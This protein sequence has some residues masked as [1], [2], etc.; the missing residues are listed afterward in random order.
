MTLTM[1]QAR[2][3]ADMTQQEV[4]DVLGVHVQ[5]YMKYEAHPEAMPLR[6]A[7]KFAD[8]MGVDFA[9]IFLDADSKKIRQGGAA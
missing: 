1:K 8:A 7:G 5:T 3:G 2:V 6:V 4:A 9:D